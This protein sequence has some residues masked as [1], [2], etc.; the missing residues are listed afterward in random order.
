V[1]IGEKT[2][3]LYNV[4]FQSIHLGYED[5]AAIDEMEQKRQGKWQNVKG[6]M[7]KMKQAYTNRALQAKKVRQSLNSYD[8]AKVLCGDFNDVPVSFAYN[9]VRGEMQDAF[10][11]KGS[12]FG[13]TFVN[14]LSIFRID[15]IF[16]GPEIKT[17]SYK[18]IKEP[19]SDHY[20]VCVTFSF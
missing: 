18:T 19:L 10:V 16:M 3:R 13:A 8:G 2:L 12:G 11:E 15:H 17:G 9:T 4:H 14:K 20:P 1:K 6:I 5:Y 7:R